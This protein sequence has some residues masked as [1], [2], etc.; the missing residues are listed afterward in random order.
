MK[1]ISLPPPTLNSFSE[2]TPTPGS[3]DSDCTVITSLPTQDSQLQ[4]QR[5]PTFLTSS[6]THCSKPPSLVLWPRYSRHIFITLIGYLATWKILQDHLGAA[7]GT[8]R[9]LSHPSLLTPTQRGPGSLGPDALDLCLWFAHP[10]L[11]YSQCS[12]INGYYS[13]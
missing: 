10:R 6:L 1:A 4:R 13:L 11:F 2:L 12:K 8:Q 3:Q 9:H 7:S 5:P